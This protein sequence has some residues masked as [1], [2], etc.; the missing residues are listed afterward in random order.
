MDAK[1][2]IQR[3]LVPSFVVTLIYL[4]RYRCKVSPRAE[5]ELSPR[6]RIG[7][8]T[9]IGSF[10]KIKA[11][12]GDL[13]IGKNVH[14]GTG[15]FISAEAGGVSIGDWSMISPNVCIVGNDYRYD[16]LDIPVARQEKTSK[17]VRIGSDVWIGAG[18]VVMDG[19]DIAD[20]CI[21]TPNSVVNGKLDTGTVAQG[22]PA[23]RVFV[24]RS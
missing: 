9:E 5:V 2:V 22:M 15:C 1:K 12:D 7:E 21:V 10:T 24:R 19:A 14:I 4:V 3:F 11:T 17:G 13:D 20:H 6:L 16:R 8:G 18:C 23:R